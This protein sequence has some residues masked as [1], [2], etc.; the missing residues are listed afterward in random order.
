MRYLLV[1][2][3]CIALLNSCK[4]DAVPDLLLP[5]AYSN[6]SVGASAN[7]LLSSDKFSALIV[8]INFMPGFTPDAAALNHFKTFLENTLNKQGGIEIRQRQI[9]SSN[10]G[11]YTLNDI[12]AIEKNNRTVYSD[13]NTIGVYCLITDAPYTEN[14]VLGV[15]YRNTSFVLM[16]KTIHNNS[17]GI[18]QASRTKVEATVLEHEFGHL[19]GLVNIGSPMQSDHQD[20]AHGNHCTDADCLM[21]YAAETTDVLG[22]LITGTIPPL[23]AACKSDLQAN[24]GK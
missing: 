18:G 1:C 9:A 22:F 23:D 11:T 5:H 24:G 19:L 14:N 21:S 10:Q 13:G 8:E 6:K 17:G 15:A 2:F 7:D 12:K 4:K 20:H 3:Y 16:G